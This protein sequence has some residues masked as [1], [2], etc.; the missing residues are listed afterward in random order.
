MSKSYDAI[1]I[2]S[3]GGPESRDDVIPFLE[4]VLR[5]K[6]VPR[7]RLLEVA[8]HYYLF[9]G[10]SPINQQNR[11]LIAALTKELETHGPRL[12]IYWGNRN[13]Q[14]LLTDTLR[15]MKND[16]V[17]H[18]I[19]FFTSSFSSYSGC[20]QYRENIVKSQ[21]EVGKG[22]PTVDKLRSFYNHPR[23]IEANV[24]RVQ[25]ALRKI[26][27]ERHSTTQLVFTAHSIPIAMAEGSDYTTQL[28]EAV[29]L[30]TEQVGLPDARLVYQSR[31]GPPS[32]PWLQPDVGDY[33]KS[34]KE[35]GR[36]TDVVV[37]PIGFLSDHMEV[38]FDLDTEVRDLCN[39]IGL[40]MVRAKTV[41]THP[42]LV[43]MI[44]ELL[45]ERVEGHPR[46]AVGRL[47][48]SVDACPEDCCLLGRQKPP[49]PAS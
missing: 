21:E 39:Q 44:R 10:I 9:G 48:P 43:S 19:A 12:P 14:P 47:G 16:G 3:F 6:N 31:S 24:D 5:G 36:Y 18:A 30:V 17:Q 32:Q 35:R 1:L 41:G 28:R 20:R 11:A 7:E 49:S 15:Q 8:E 42:A 37:V 23:F 29:R 26:P 25:A 46:R 34:L 4:N 2:L 45:L 22:V 13:W 38:L 27:S 40:N 33:L